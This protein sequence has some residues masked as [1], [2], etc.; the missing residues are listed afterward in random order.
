MDTSEQT[1]GIEVAV[2]R[3]PSRRRVETLAV[4]VSAAG[5]SY[6]I[7]RDHAVW[8]LFVPAA[9]A[10]RARAEIA[11]FEE[12][13]RAWPP[14]AQEPVPVLSPRPPTILLAGALAGFYLI[15]GPWALDT[16]WFRIG[17]VA[18]ERILSHGEWWRLI[19]ALTLHAD[20]VHVVGNMLIGGVIIHLLCRQM[21]SALGLFLVLLSG[22]LGNA[23]NVLARQG[24]HLSVGFSTAVFGGLGILAGQELWRRRRAAWRGM[25]LPLAAAL[26]LLAML[27][28]EGEHTDLGAHLFGLAAGLLL[29][30]AAA[31]L[32]GSPPARLPRP[33]AWAL[34]IASLAVVVGAWWLAIRNS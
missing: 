31:V 15:T 25:L 2:I 28:A 29:G 16:I 14:P 1:D 10:F 23:A 27:G 13:E 33:V 24:P 32:P 12:E 21:G 3:S 34:G 9:E 20:P 19:T 8:G 17:A 5:I 11:R 18:S 22:A 7:D 26:A 4:V 30:L 6:R